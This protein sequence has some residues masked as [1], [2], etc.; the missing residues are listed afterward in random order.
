M[1][2]T[3][4]IRALGAAAALL[5]TPL[6]LGGCAARIPLAAGAIDAEIQELA[7]RAEEGDKQAQ[8]ELG[9][10]FEEG[11]GLPVDL[12]RAE[13][14]YRRAARDSGG[15]VWAYAPS[16]AGTPG[17]AFPVRSEPR[18]PGLEEARIRLQRVRCARRHRDCESSRER[19][20]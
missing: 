4:T 9:I 13:R 8:L 16:V 12:R 7:L 14:L 1:G 3:G 17:H 15:T 20:R 6:A 2:F 5:L 19:V 18:Q 11:R 10:R